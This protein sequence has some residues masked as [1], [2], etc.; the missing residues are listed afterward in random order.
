[1]QF[2]LKPRNPATNKF[3]ACS[4]LLF[5]LIFDLLHAQT[6]GPDSS[7]A[8]SF[9][10]KVRVVLLDVVVTDK[11]DPISNLKKDDFQVFEDGVPQNISY[12]EEHK[13]M[14]P[15]Q[16]KPPE[17][18]PNVYTNY[19]LTKS[20]DAAN[21]L[22]LDTLNTP[23]QDQAYVRGQMIKYLKT[24]K[25]GS[26]MAIFSLGSR[27][28]ILQGFTDDPSNLLFA[29]NDKESVGTHASSLQVTSA[30]K[31]ENAELLAHLAANM[32][33]QETI[34]AVRRFQ[35]DNA[36]ARNNERVEITLQALQDLARY[37]SEIPGRKNVIWFSS[38]FPISVFPNAEEPRRFNNGQMY[39]ADIANTAKLL[40]VNQVAIYPISA[41][42]LTT[43]GRYDAAFTRAPSIAQGNSERAANQIAME[44][45]AKDTGGQAFYN[46]N[47]LSQAVAH[48]VNDGTHYYTLTYTPSNIKMDGK[49]RKIHIQLTHEN[50]RLAYRRGYYAENAKKEQ[51]EARLPQSD[52]LLPLV[53]FGMPNLSQILYKVRVTPSSQ[54]PAAGAPLAGG[55]KELKGPRKRYEVEFAVLEKDLKLQLAHDGVRHGQIEELVI[56]YDREGKPLNMVVKRSQL[57]LKPKTYEEFLHNGVQL[58]DEI[59]VPASIPDGSIYIHTG[60]YDAASS[61]AGT[62]ALLLNNPAMPP[63]SK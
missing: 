19:P 17:L 40:T 50:Y 24:L 26:R 54:Q 41:T 12:F 34:D 59:D 47:G 15:A 8:P 49:F 33:A 52:P 7:Q 58:R 10:S 45:L 2:M 13:G 35:Q 1:V 43:D 28:R 14:A 20:Q 61:K 36:D 9:R 18:P 39:A 5:F 16:I 42:G 63:A 37:L 27:L 29:L 62:L 6:V 51:A 48:V 31:D 11:E 23:P 57:V 32:A 53:G 21:V 56:A 30:E 55:N 46:T 4:I 22:L 60:I 3:L 44:A 38:S 25:P